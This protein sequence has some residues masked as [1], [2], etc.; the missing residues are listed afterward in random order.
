LAPDAT[1]GTPETTDEAPSFLVSISVGKA[2]ARPTDD[3]TVWVYVNDQTGRPLEGAAVTLIVPTAS[4]QRTISL[5][6]TDQWGHTQT[7]FTLDGLEPR[8]RAFLQATV[9]YQ[10]RTINAQASFTVWW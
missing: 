6:S 3:Q 8:R 1:P 5:P 10:G 9:S 7:T 2:V 4:G